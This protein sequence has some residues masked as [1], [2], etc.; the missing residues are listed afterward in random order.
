MYSA[1][2]EG[3]LERFSQITPKLLFS[4]NAVV[5]NGKVHDHL[6]KLRSVVGQLESL[7][8]VV[9]FRSIDQD[10]ELTDIQNAYNLKIIC[11]ITIRKGNIWNFHW[12][13]Q[14]NEGN[15]IWTAPIWSSCIHLIQLWDNW[16]TKM[17]CT[18]WWRDSYSTFE[19]THN[20]W[21]HDKKGR[22][23]LLYN[24]WLDDV[25]LACEWAVSWIDDC[26]IWWKSIQTNNKYPMA[27][28]WKV[29]VKNT[30]SYQSFIFYFN[31]L[32]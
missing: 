4:V 11:M 14:K 30:E 18:F 24:Y 9:V 20:T 17:Y 8:K 29:Q 10:F 13:F 32:S 27:P 5:Y 23:F 16:Q 6:E 1:Y 7:E 3:V 2:I 15:R 22:L 21:E 19:G 25:E 31:L 12:E 26:F 28:G